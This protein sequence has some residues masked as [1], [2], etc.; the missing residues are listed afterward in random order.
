[1]IYIS[2]FNKHTTAIIY[3]TKFNSKEN[4]NL[5]L[6]LLDSIPM[7]NYG[8]SDS[9][10]TSCDLNPMKIF[11]LFEEHFNTKLEKAGTMTKDFNFKKILIKNGSEIRIICK[12]KSMRKL[13]KNP[14]INKYFGSFQNI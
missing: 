11:N 1:M 12:H 3:D 9:T 2:F 8:E 4:N 13:F 5:I 7:L 6:H 14:S 10:L